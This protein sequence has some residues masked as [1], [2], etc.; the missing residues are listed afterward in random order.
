[1]S[2][3]TNRTR[4]AARPLAPTGYLYMIVAFLEAVTWAGLLVGMYQKYILGLSDN[5][6][7]LFGGL[8]GLVFMLYVAITWLVSRALKWDLRT[9]AL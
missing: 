2:D 9:T 6:V 8:H 1:M 7:P 4:M 5:L 3:V